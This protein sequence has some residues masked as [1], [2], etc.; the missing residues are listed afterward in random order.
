MSGAPGGRKPGPGN[1]FHLHPFTQRKPR[2]SRKSA[3]AR[4]DPEHTTSELANT[5]PDGW[6][7]PRPDSAASG[8]GTAQNNGWNKSEHEGLLSLYDG[9]KRWYHC[10]HCD[11]MNDRLYHSKMHYQRIHIKNGK[12]MPRKRKYTEGQ[13][14]P[15]PAAPPLRV[16]PEFVAPAPNKRP[17]APARLAG[18]LHHSARPEEDLRCKLFPTPSGYSTKASRIAPNLKVVQTPDATDPEDAQEVLNNS[19]RY[20]FQGGSIG[21]Q[22]GGGPGFSIKAE[23]MSSPSSLPTGRSTI[24]GSGNASLR[25]RNKRPKDVAKTPRAQT[26]RRQ[27]EAE[28]Q[29]VLSHDMLPLP[30]SAKKITPS[31]GRMEP[32]FE[33]GNN[34][35]STA[36]PSSA[37][38]HAQ[39]SPGKPARSPTHSTPTTPSRP[40]KF[41]DLCGNNSLTDAELCTHTPL[42]DANPRLRTLRSATPEARSLQMLPPNSCAVEY[43]RSPGTRRPRADSSDLLRCDEVM[44]RDDMVSAQPVSADDVCGGEIAGFNFDSLLAQTH[45]SVSGSFVWAC[46]SWFVVNG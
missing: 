16:Y 35:A 36:P 26:G 4:E 12:S 46:G 15:R 28:R 22:N 44:S 30:L 17:N 5:A 31:P 37:R 18:T 27:D 7:T 10:E 39:G 29:E 38:Q 41:N 6:H 34:S 42:A 40:G 23:E 3:E 1:T 33:H 9:T 45:F 20:T 14:G 32:S 2:A 21:C 43:S 25:Q 13:D 11:Y 19:V 24:S 8:E